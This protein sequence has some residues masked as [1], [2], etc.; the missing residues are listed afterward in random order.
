MNIHWEDIFTFSMSPFEMIIRG[1]LTYW[2]IFLLLRFAGR[3]DIGSIGMADLLVVVLISDAAQNAMAGDYKSVPDG[4]VL[5][6]T[7][8]LWTVCI[9]RIAYHWPASR[10]FLHPPK[11]CIV[12]DGE[13][14]RR[15]M[16]RESLTRDEL[17]SELRQKGIVDLSEVSRAY[18]ESDGAI[19]VIKRRDA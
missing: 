7:I 5:I 2:F 9:D 15:A 10:P 3:R 1:S 8:V 18:I 14:Q 11:L 19:S 6:A 16:R 17:D 13:L 12:K 4:M